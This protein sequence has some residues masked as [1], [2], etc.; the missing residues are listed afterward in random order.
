[1]LWQGRNQRSSALLLVKT[2]G[3][4]ILSELNPWLITTNKLAHIFNAYSLNKLMPRISIQIP[5]M[6]ILVH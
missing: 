1:V 2:T 5:K 6:F 4:L 3:E